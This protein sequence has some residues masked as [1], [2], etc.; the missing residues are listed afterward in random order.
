MPKISVQSPTQYVKLF[1]NYETYKW[2]SCTCDQKYRKHRLIAIVGWRCPELCAPRYVSLFASVPPPRMYRQA[3][4]KMN[5]SIPPL[6][7]PACKRLKWESW[8]HGQKSYYFFIYNHT[9]PFISGE[10]LCHKLMY[11]IKTNHD[12][13]FVH[14]CPP[15]K[16]PPTMSQL[17]LKNNYENRLI[18]S[19]DCLQKIGGLFKCI[20]YIAFLVCWFNFKYKWIMV[21]ETHT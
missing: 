21:Y 18:W 17:V 14:Q 12:T 8:D 20:M 10:K 15:Y 16:K 5:S 7:S 2:D 13:K 11:F 4:Y 1:I 3:R 9:L 6:P 19:L